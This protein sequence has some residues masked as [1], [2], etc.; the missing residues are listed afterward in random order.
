MSLIMLPYLAEI[1]QV[2]KLLG[3]GVGVNRSK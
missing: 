2:Q 1:P 3:E